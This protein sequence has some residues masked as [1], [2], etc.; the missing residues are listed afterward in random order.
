M[1]SNVQSHPE[2]FCTDANHVLKILHDRIRR[3]DLDFHPAI[4]KI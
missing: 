2:E 3:E 4:E 1:A